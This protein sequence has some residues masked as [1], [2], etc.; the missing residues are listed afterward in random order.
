M[1][2]PGQ[3]LAPTWQGLV[4]RLARPLPFSVSASLNCWSPMAC[5]PSRNAV[6][7][8]DVPAGALG[9]H[10]KQRAQQVHAFYKRSRR[11][12]F[13]LVCRHTATT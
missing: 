9:F 3:W 2:L 5:T 13:E 10:C 11:R 8:G 6:L 12:K 1:S 7:G 4:R